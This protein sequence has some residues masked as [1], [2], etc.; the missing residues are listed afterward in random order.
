MMDLDPAVNMPYLWHKGKDFCKH[1]K[2]S[3][4]KGKEV[5]V[6]RFQIVWVH[7]ILRIYLHTFPLLG[8]ITSQRQGTV[9]E[10]G[11]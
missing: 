4:G 11:G 5:K 8:S 6:V 7:K 9:L 10:P 1:T 2:D 3:K